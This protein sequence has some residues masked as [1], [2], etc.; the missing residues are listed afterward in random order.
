[1]FVDSLNTVVS[2]FGK[3]LVT[4]G[5]LQLQNK[6]GADNAEE[7]QT[8]DAAVELFKGMLP[9]EFGNDNQ[10]GKLLT[11][12]LDTSRS[13]EQASK[14]AKAKEVSIGLL[15]ML[16]EQDRF[17]IVTFWGDNNVLQQPVKATKENIEKAIKEVEDVQAKQGTLIGEALNAAFKLIAKEPL[18]NKQ[19]ML[20]TDGASWGQASA[21]MNPPKII[22]NMRSAGIVTSVV[23]LC[24]DVEK[25]P[26]KTKIEE[27]GK[28]GGGNVYYISGNSAADIMLAEIA[29][30]VGEKIIEIPTQVNVALR[31]D[32]LL[33]GVKQTLSV[34]GFVNN[35]AKA[36]A[37][38]V[39][40]AQYSPIGTGKVDVPIYAYKDYRD[41]DGRVSSF[42]SKFAWIDHWKENGEWT[43]DGAG[44][45][46][47]SNI[48]KANTP[49]Q[50]TE[51]PFDVQIT[52]DGTNANV[53]LYPSRLRP[54]AVV[55]IEVS[56]PNVE[57][58]QK[59]TL[60]FQTN[61]YSYDFK[62][63]TTGKY[64]IKMTYTYAGA[65]EQEP[66]SVFFDI[67][68]SPEYDAFQAYDPADI[69]RFIRH[70]GQI[71]TDGTVDLSNDGGEVATYTIDFTIPFAIAVVVLFV[72]DIMIRK[73][74]WSDVK[75]LFKK[76]KPNVKKGG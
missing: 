75:G 24:N 32:E 25:P 72:I 68:Y 40:T 67:A 29:D 21:E 14:Y 42:T 4:F 45:Q 47:L 13:M 49:K 23:N 55:G 27:M 26:N 30:D 3:S 8:P 17:A 9:I 37:T 76:R 6:M 66:I 70:R 34:N 7:E 19:I 51:S 58:T 15:E 52:Y 20:V 56:I 63:P 74:K 33:D 41:S 43:K 10:D 31:G 38:T 28:A 36:D 16:T 53:S 1:M 64:T 5:D 44:G 11:I 57:E 48:F 71:T 12:V 22:E 65:P 50:K 54:D 61:G 18:K 59:E 39:L 62:T 73:L 69:H 2:Q 60:Y 46:L 35:T